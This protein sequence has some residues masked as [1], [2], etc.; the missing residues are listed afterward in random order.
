MG[1][2]VG[3]GEEQWWNWKRSLQIQVECGVDGFGRWG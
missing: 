3:K 2:A 1:I